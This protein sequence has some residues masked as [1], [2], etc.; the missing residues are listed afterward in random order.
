MP[1]EL[2]GI[3]RG[4]RVHRVWVDDMGQRLVEAARPVAM[5]PSCSGATPINTGTT[6]TGVPTRCRHE[7]M[8]DSHRTQDDRSRASGS[9][10]MTA[11]AHD[12]RAA[13]ILRANRSPSVS[14][15]SSRQTWYPAPPTA[16][17]KEANEV[18]GQRPRPPATSGARV[19]IRIGPIASGAPTVADKDLSLIRHSRRRLQASDR[20]SSHGPISTVLCR[21]RPQPN[22]SQHIADTRSASCIDGARSPGGTPGCSSQGD[23][24]PQTTAHRRSLIRAVTATCI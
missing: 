17:L 3:V 15:G 8:A 24:P 5:L 23:L 22:R 16:L 11:P 6:R 14:E 10:K 13:S 9:S 19:G 7:R 12:S 20:R 1:L 18:E 21:A 2:S 4:I